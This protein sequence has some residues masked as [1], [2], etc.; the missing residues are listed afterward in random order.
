[1]N[2]RA[3]HIQS[4]IGR[5]FVTLRPAG[6]G[7]VAR[8]D[9]IG[10]TID[11]FSSAERFR[12]AMGREPHREV[13]TETLLAEAPVGHTYVVDREWPDGF[14]IDPGSIESAEQIEPVPQSRFS[15]STVPAVASAIAT[16]NSSMRSAC[17][18]TTSVTVSP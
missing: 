15:T 2:R 14:E 13:T 12:Q 4:L 10:A 8:P 18:A 11:V 7:F 3:N 9:D 1:M 17:T 6:D 5:T 16:M